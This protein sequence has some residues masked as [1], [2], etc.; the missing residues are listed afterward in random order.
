MQFISMT[1]ETVSHYIA[2]SVTADELVIAEQEATSK[3]GR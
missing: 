1:H 2:K 3:H